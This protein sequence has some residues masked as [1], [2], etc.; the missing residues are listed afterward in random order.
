MSETVQG[1]FG[2]AFGLAESDPEF[3]EFFEIFL[4]RDVA[5]FGEVEPATERMAVL[6]ALAGAQGKEA[7]EV[8]LPGSAA[9]GV[10]PEMLRE[11]VYQSVAY[12]G[13]GRAYPFI[14]AVSRYLNAHGLLPLEAASTTTPQTRLQAGSQKQVDL[15]GEHMRDFWKS[16]PEESMH[17]NRWLA[18]NCFGD[19]YTRKGLDDR[20]RELITFCFLA[21]QGGCEPQLVSHAAANMR[22]GNDKTFL[23][24]VLSRCL[25]YIGYPRSLNALRCINEAANSAK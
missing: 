19:Y 4:T 22:I 18:Q 10:T 25:P 9:C 1:A 7:F 15:F 11:I 5:A 14:L 6:S 12:L 20:S 3:S 23:I 13:F 2:K 16:G 24:A 8:L 17:I 21:A